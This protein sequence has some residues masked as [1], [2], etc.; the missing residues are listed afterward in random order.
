MSSIEEDLFDR[1][2][3]VQLIVSALVTRMEANPDRVSHVAFEEALHLLETAN[4]LAV[5]MRTGMGVA[6]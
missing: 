6:A 4:H 3:S 5:L 1:A 2:V